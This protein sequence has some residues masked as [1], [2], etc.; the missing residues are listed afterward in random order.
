MRIQ[1]VQPINLLDVAILTSG[2]VDMF[3]KCLDSV[4][5]ETSGTSAKIYIVEQGVPQESLP[6]YDEVYE[7][8]PKSAQVIRLR[9]NRGYPFGMNKAMKAGNAPLILSVSD[10]VTLHPGSI[11]ALL[12]RMDDPAIGLCGLKLLFPADSIDPHR[13]AGRVQHVGHSM[14]I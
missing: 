6:L 8:L 2:R 11:H 4:L 12:K 9:D 14:N 3:R 5:S 13:P 10:D 7:K 1:Q